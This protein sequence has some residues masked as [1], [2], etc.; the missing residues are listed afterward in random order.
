MN[1]VS[2]IKTGRANARKHARKSETML[3]LGD[4][5]KYTQEMIETA[6]MGGRLVAKR[7]GIGA[8]RVVRSGGGGGDVGAGDGEG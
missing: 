7:P 3:C 6:K 8:W 5:Y 1:N 2:A 4:I